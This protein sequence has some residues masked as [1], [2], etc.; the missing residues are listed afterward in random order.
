MKK[1]LTVFA[2]LVTILAISGA[3][4][5]GVLYQTGFEPTTYNLGPVGGQDGWTAG[6]NPDAF[7]VQNAIYKGSQ[8]VQVLNTAGSSSADRRMLASPVSVGST[9]IVTYSYDVYLSDMW[10]N[11]IT[12]DYRDLGVGVSS[13]NFQNYPS[14]AFLRPYVD[15]GMGDTGFKMSL[16]G[17]GNRFIHQA[18]P[19]DTWFNLAMVMNNGTGIVQA[20]L[21]GGLLDTWQ[22]TAGQLFIDT[23]PPYNGGPRIQSI[24]DVDLLTY[25]GWSNGSAYVDN[26][27]LSIVPEPATLLLLGLGTLVLL[28]KRK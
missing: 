20:F 6:S 25:G 19:T 27:S 13:T 11:E 4:Q 2:A 1:M 23:N 16:D 7:T 3:V 5:A 12:G 26:V 18:L 17:R 9:D 15:S 8:A 10:V 22:L 28:R 14:Y 24:T 21:N